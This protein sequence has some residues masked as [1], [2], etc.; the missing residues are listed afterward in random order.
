MAASPTNAA[1]RRPPWL[2]TAAL[3]TPAYGWLLVAVFLP[4]G[5]MLVFSFFKT[6]PF[7]SK[8]PMVF[9][10]ANYLAFVTRPYLV[11]VAWTSL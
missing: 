7:G 11:D 6:N 4:L 9:T 2:A 5:A 8:A 1:P 3:L 10:S